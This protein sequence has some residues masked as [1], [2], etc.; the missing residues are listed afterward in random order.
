MA[1]FLPLCDQALSPPFLSDKMIE[2]GKFFASQ[3]IA[4]KQKISPFIFW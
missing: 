4:Y 1:A 3:T 2:L